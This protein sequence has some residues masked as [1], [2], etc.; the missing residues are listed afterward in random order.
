MGSHE[1]GS[2][3]H[4]QCTEIGEFLRRPVCTEVGCG[5][6]RQCCFALLP[7]SGCRVPRMAAK[8]SRIRSR[9]AVGLARY[10][11]PN[12]PR[13]W[14]LVPSGSSTCQIC[15][16]AKTHHLIR[17][18]HQRTSVARL[19]AA[20]RASGSDLEGCRHRV[21]P[22][23]GMVRACPWSAGYQVARAV[24]ASS[25]PSGSGVRRGRVRQGTVRMSTLY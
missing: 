19:D 18:H 5:M 14:G 21:V 4:R 24:L 25:A 22:R 8:R 15:A 17:A 2:K 6:P 12:P 3:K 13:A 10:S 20:G 23:S 9:H 7:E 1:A 11:I 16:G